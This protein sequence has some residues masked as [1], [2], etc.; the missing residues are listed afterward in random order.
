M[1]PY[2]FLS[3][4]LYRYNYLS[5][6]PSLLPILRA[7]VC[8]GVPLHPP[9]ITCRCVDAG[10]ILMSIG[11]LALMIP[12]IMRIK[13]LITRLNLTSAEGGGGQVRGKGMIF[14]AA[15]AAARGRRLSDSSLA[16]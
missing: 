14:L 10:Q 11:G 1:D 6:P 3:V 7:G 15:P 9:L 12:E 2:I 13:S 8:E 5:V 16:K 4:Y